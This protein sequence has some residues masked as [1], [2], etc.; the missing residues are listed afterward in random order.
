[1]LIEFV[2]M[3]CSSKSALRQTKAKPKRERAKWSKTTTH[4]VL[5]YFSDWI[6]NTEQRGLPGKADILNFL[7]IHGDIKYE[8][9]LIRNKVL[10]EKMAYAKRKKVLLDNL[11]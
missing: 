1:M 10:N 4:A 2:L 3:F 6:E 5:S 8:W 11:V 9:T 7:K